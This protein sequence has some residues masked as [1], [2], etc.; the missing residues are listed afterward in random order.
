LH[1]A[2]GGDVEETVVVEIAH[3]D[4]FGAEGTVER[5]SLKLTFAGL[6]SAVA[7]EAGRGGRGRWGSA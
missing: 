1:H 5:G 7:F 6:L 3:A 2:A 4:A